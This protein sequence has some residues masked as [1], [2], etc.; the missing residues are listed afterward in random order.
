MA[1]EREK[2][3]GLKP[4]D[5]V[6]DGGGVMSH[7]WTVQTVAEGP[8]GKEVLLRRRNHNFD[9]NKDE[10]V[11]ATCYWDDTHDTIANVQTGQPHEDLGRD[12][13]FIPAE[14]VERVVEEMLALGRLTPEEADRLNKAGQNNTL[15]G[16]EIGCD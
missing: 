13:A 6:M 11:E 9:G 8:N 16:I 7:T 10:V 4:F 12:C 1:I 14:S 5:R 15:R 2:F 3:L